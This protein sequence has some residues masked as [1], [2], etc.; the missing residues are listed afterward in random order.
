[1]ASRFRI[2]VDI[3]GTFTDGVLV[4]PD[5]EITTAKVLTTPDDPSRGFFHAVE[6]LLTAGQAGPSDVEAIGHATTVATNAIIEGKLKPMA[7]ITTSGFR[8][9]LEIA[10]QNR[11]HLYDFFCEK[12]LPLIPRHLV[13]EIDERI[14]P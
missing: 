6:V 12:P 3:G 14:G 10:R 4:D 9:M 8:D 7:M 13:F 11:P 1:M 2:A 5:G